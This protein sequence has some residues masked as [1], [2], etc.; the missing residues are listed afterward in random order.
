MK[1]YK[2]VKSYID[3]NNDAK[4]ELIGAFASIEDARHE[5]ANQLKASLS[6]EWEY[7]ESVSNADLK[8]LCS[9]EYW[10]DVDWSKYRITKFIRLVRKGIKTNLPFAVN[11]MTYSLITLENDEF[12]HNLTRVVI[13]ECD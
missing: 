3:D 13:V 10:Q 1:S 5:L 4:T 6:W 7:F 12:K 2:V 11:Y 8:N 9:D